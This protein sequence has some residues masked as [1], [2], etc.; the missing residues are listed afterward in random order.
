VTITNGYC[1]QA[2][3]RTHL[4]D[5]SSIIDSGLM[6]RAI[7][8]AS[9]AIDRHCG[10]RF[11]QD[12]APQTK[13]YVPHDYWDLWVDDISTTTGLV[14]KLDTNFDGSFSSTLPVGQY[15]LEPLNADTEA[16]AFAWWR[17]RIISNGFQYFPIWYRHQATVAV[18][19]QFGWS[20]IPDQVAEA[21]LLKA[22]SL[23]KRKDS[24]NG[25]MGFTDFGGVRISRYD[26]DVMS[27]L[28]PYRKVG[29]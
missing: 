9:R 4:G 26:P 11:W 12:P 16:T 15:Q 22:A 24:P 2:D 18:T 1:S 23:L 27:L 19:A 20:A 13:K 7:N 21:C 14:I 5:A 8:A 17:I 10:R 6:D 25:V 3:L 28:S 29:V